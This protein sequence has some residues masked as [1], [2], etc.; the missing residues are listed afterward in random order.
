MESTVVRATLEIPRP[1]PNVLAL[2]VS[3]DLSTMP[4][5]RLSMLGCELVR[6]KKKF[7]LAS[8]IWKSACSYRCGDFLLVDSYLLM[9]CI[10]GA[11]FQINVHI[12]VY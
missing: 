5:Q 2:D 12:S 6:K 9:S 8:C 7:L 4:V 1:I 11:P 10:R 3:G